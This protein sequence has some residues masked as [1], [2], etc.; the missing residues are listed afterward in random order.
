M[1][2]HTTRTAVPALLD[3]L[4]KRDDVASVEWDD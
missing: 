3:E 2:V 1:S 4:I